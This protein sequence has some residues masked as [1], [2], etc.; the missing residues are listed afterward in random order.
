MIGALHLYAA[1]RT[2]SRR[3]ALPRSALL[4]NATPELQRNSRNT[5][6]P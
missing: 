4:R 5:Q 3:H 2:A 1:Q 6:W